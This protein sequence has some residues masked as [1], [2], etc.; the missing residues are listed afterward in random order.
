M[1]RMESKIRERQVVFAISG[2][3]NLI[4]DTNTDFLGPLL[5]GVKYDL[6]YFLNNPYV[7]GFEELLGEA[8]GLQAEKS[9]KEF[10]MYLR[11]EF[12]VEVRDDDDDDDDDGKAL[13]LRILNMLKFFKDNCSGQEYI[14]G[15]CEAAQF[16]LLSL[17]YIKFISDN[18]NFIT[19]DK[20]W[21]HISKSVPHNIILA[22]HSEFGERNIP[23]AGTLINFYINFFKTCL[24]NK[25]QRIIDRVKG[26]TYDIK[27]FLVLLINILLSTDETSK[28]LGFKR[29]GRFNDAGVRGKTDHI[30]WFKVMQKFMKEKNIW[31]AVPPEDNQSG[32]HTFVEQLK[33]VGFSNKQ[34]VTLEG[35]GVILNLSDLHALF[36]KVMSGDG[37]NTN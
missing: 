2:P 9:A 1:E 12:G 35:N 13:V 37:D 17:F 20:V 8:L 22:Y 6:K 21:T 4:L 11:N 31:I 3:E 18:R 25:K 5:G 10:L 7:S 16:I 14:V 26:I 24:Q 19:D 23:D 36:Q 33:A 29:S 15:Y 34:V 32:L 30:F 27:L 28:L